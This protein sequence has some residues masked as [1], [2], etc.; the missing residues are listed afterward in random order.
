RVEPPQGR[1]AV[2]GT[3]GFFVGIDGK[4][5]TA[6][7]DPD[8]ADMVDVLV[9]D[10]NRG[11]RS[12]QHVDASQRVL[13]RA[14]AVAGVDQ[15]GSAAIRDKD[16]IPAAAAEKRASPDHSTSRISAPKAVSLLI[17]SSY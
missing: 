11:E 7:H 15:D 13:D 10:Q 6:H 17:K 4:V 5:V 9:G 3:P 2:H 12:G 14:S 1:G 8:S 16:R